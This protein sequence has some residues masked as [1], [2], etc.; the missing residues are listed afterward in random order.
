MPVNASD[1]GRPTRGGLPC[2]FQRGRC[3]GCAPNVTGS[4]VMSIDPEPPWQE[5]TSSTPTAWR[6]VSGRGTRVAA[7]PG[8]VAGSVW[9]PSVPLGVGDEGARRGEA[10]LTPGGHR[11]APTA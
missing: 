1:Q 4:T 2:A 3:T 10:D 7:G 5:V 11:S 6:E 9:T 8:V